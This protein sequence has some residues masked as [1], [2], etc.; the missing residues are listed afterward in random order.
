MFKALEA[1]VLF[2]MSEMDID[3]ITVFLFNQ[4]DIIKWIHG[5]LSREFRIDQEQYT[6]VNGRFHTRR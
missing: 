4:K 2:I 3:A 1:L 6:Q 5:W